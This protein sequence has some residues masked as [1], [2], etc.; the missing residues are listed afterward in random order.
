MAIRV[1]R[2]VRVVRGVSYIKRVESKIPFIHVLTATEETSQVGAGLK[3]FSSSKKKKERRKKNLSLLD[4]SASPQVKKS[5][6]CPSG[7]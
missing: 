2:V 1:V 4:L 7:Q 3:L 6:K 5:S